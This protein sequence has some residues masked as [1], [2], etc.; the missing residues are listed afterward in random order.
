MVIDHCIRWCI[1]C[2]QRY[3][4]S[5]YSRIKKYR[6]IIFGGYSIAHGF[7]NQWW[8]ASLV[9]ARR[10]PKHI[11]ECILLTSLEGWTDDGGRES[12][13]GV[14]PTSFAKIINKFWSKPMS[15]GANAPGENPTRCTWRGS[16][17]YLHG[18]YFGMDRLAHIKAGWKLIKAVGMRLPRIQYILPQ[19]HITFFSFRGF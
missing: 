12:S 18:E 1:D 9:G 7:L 4:T 19:R 10:E 5:I 14:R 2:I 13:S 15:D 17:R 3:C 11:V 6:R 8:A 16:L